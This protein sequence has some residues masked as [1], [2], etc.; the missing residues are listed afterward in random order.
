MANSPSTIGRITILMTFGL[1]A[2]SPNAVQAEGL[3]TGLAGV[4]FGGDTTSEA[5]TYGFGLAATA[6]G[7]FGF[8]IDVA[9]TTNILGEEAVV[10]D[11]AITTVMGN[12]MVGLGGPVRPYVTGGA[13]LIRSTV[14]GLSMGSVASNDFGVNIGGGIIGFVTDHVGIRGDLRYFRSVSRDADGDLLDFDLQLGD[15]DFWRGTVGVTLAW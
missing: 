2:F 10:G 5:T 3:L 14:D 7:V 8:E 12:L 9:T 13:G 1:V 6:G 11:S 4:T 15:L